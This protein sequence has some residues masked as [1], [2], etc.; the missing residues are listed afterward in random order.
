MKN[1]NFLPLITTSVIVIIFLLFLSSNIFVTIQSGQ[2][3]VLYEKFGSGTVTDR[4]YSE[5]FHIKA[6]W[7]TMYIYNVR[8]QEERMEMEVLS[9]NGLSIIVD[10]SI[11]YRPTLADLGRMQKEIGQDYQNVI[12]T[13]EVRSS[14]RKVIGEYDPEEL[15]ST[16]RDIIQKEIYDE[17]KA[18]VEEKYILLD[19]ILIRSVVLPATIKTAIENKLKQEQE[20]KEYEF[21][22]EKELKEAERK[23]IE[24]QGIKDFQDIV[25]EGISD[26][27][28]KWKGIES[29]L[30]LAKSQNSKVVIIG[31][32]KDGLPIILGGG[33]DK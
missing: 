16:K 18:N 15:Y 14:V 20:S 2:A 26:K 4:Y 13:P 29:T 31:G 6:P 33:D 9:K 23:K 5:G 7:N 22:L 28:L 19:A 8:V 21:R 25:S 10:V 24:A 3:G 30:E 1:K 17:T 27:L 32:G 11:R 12:I